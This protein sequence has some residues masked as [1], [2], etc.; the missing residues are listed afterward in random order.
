MKTRLIA[1]TILR[2]LRNA[3]TCIVLQHV[4]IK[5]N[6]QC[7]VH[8]A[9]KGRSRHIFGRFWL[10]NFGSE[11]FLFV[12]WES[13]SK[14]SNFFLMS[15]SVFTSRS[16][17]HSTNRGRNLDVL[18]TP[19]VNEDKTVTHGWPKSH[20]ERMWQFLIGRPGFEYKWIL[21][22]SKPMS[23]SSFKYLYIFLSFSRLMMAKHCTCPF[24]STSWWYCWLIA[25]RSPLEVMRKSLQM[26][27]TIWMLPKI[28]VPQNGWFI[29]ENPI[30]MDNLGVP[31]F[32]ETP[33]CHVMFCH[34]SHSSH[35]NLPKTGKNQ[36]HPLRLLHLRAISTPRHLQGLKGTAKVSQI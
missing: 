20:Q 35:L 14:F 26:A 13:S 10:V 9:S 4:A 28:G 27:T 25:G 36:A 24:T 29:M 31:L 30:K 34:V 11:A 19:E 16:P 22:M 6:S 7:S 33:I 5:K 2:P 18:K 15:M 12:T 23:S 8:P 21:N 1:M 17:H 3:L 32:W